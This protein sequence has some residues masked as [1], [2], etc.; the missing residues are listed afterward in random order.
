MN[1]QDGSCFH[2]QAPPPGFSSPGRRAFN[3][4]VQLTAA[5]LRFTTGGRCALLQRFSSSVKDKL[6]LQTLR[7]SRTGSVSSD[8]LFN[9]PLETQPHPVRPLGQNVTHS[10]RSMELRS[11]AIQS[12]L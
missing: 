5:D 1:G 10:G 3:M 2:A 9:N 11:S 4:Q 7:T 8:F 12:V 6:R